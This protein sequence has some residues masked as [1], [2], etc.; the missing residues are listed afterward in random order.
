M[1]DKISRAGNLIKK[2]AEVKD[3]SIH[4]TLRDLANYALILDQYIISKEKE[5]ESDGKKDTGL[6]IE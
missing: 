1:V 6:N 2:Q 4:D 3:E 5:Y